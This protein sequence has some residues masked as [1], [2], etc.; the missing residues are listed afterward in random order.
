MLNVFVKE[1]AEEL[2]VQLPD[3]RMMNLQRILEEY[4]RLLKGKSSKEAITS[5]LKVGKW[6]FIDRKILDKCQ[7]EIKSKCYV[8]G[9]EGK[10][11]WKRFENSNKIADANPDQYPSILETY[12]FDYNWIYKTEQEMRNLCTDV[13]IG[14]CDEVICNF[15]LQMRI[16][17]GESVYDLLKKADKLPRVRVIKLRNGGTGYFGGG[18]DNGYNN[19]PA[20]LYRVNFVP[21]YKHYDYVPYAFRRAL[22]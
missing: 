12:I 22:L 15:E 1:S 8:I 5:E 20:G 13:G 21:D 3:S 17:N 18:A 10:E 2:Y 14:M 11:L 9:T 7:E 16:C 19:P 6:F 4:W